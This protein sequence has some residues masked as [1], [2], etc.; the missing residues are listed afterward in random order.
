MATDGQPLLL[1]EARAEVQEQG[2]P[3]FGATPR[4]EDAFL[5]GTSE[6]EAKSVCITWADLGDFYQLSCFNSG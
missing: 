4:Q 6:G 1:P 5:S 3:Y 2:E